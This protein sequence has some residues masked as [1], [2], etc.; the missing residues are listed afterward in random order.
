MPESARKDGMFQLELSQ[1]SFARR[2]ARCLV[3]SAIH[4]SWCRCSICHGVRPSMTKAEI[5]DLQPPDSA[6]ATQ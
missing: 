2:H 5:E 4:K 1:L 6:A 3:I